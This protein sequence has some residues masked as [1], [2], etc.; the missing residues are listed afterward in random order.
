MNYQMIFRTILFFSLFVSHTLFSQ[1]CDTI[2]KN[3]VYESCISY[4]L[5]MPIQVKYKLYKGGGDCSRE[6]FRFSSEI[7]NISG[8]TE[9]T[10]SGYDR[11]HLVNAEDFAYDCTKDELTF[12]YYNCLPQTPNLN[13]GV[14]KKWENTVRNYS[15]TDSLLII[16]GGIWS[17]SNI[18]TNRLNVPVY[19]WKVVMS[20]STHQVKHVLLFTNEKKGS[21]V[22]EVSLKELEGLLKYK[23]EL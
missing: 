19:C 14:W 4:Q 2:L 5:R 20:L 6:D 18:K 7:K 21:S 23:L 17:E 3:E 9:Y 13:R 8:D 11:G 1:V 22:R 16:C 12:R 10:R 15:Q